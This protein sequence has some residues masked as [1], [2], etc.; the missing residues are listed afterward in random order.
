MRDKS[1]TSCVSFN[2]KFGYLTL[3]ATQKGLSSVRFGVYEVQQN[4]PCKTLNKAKEEILEYLTGKRRAFSSPLDMAH[5]TPMQ[6][7]LLRELKKVPYGKT[8]SYKELATKAG[9]SPRA[10]GRLLA[11]NPLPIIIPCHRV[12]KANGDLGGYKG[13]LNWKRKLI[14][15]EKKCMNNLTDKSRI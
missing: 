1:I 14:K 10:C 5:L 7:K 3:E 6:F 11:S 15:L 13:G 4:S 9:T 2:T 12:I 8:V